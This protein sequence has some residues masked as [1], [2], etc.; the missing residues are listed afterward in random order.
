[1]GKGPNLGFPVDQSPQPAAPRKLYR[2]DE[3]GRIRVV[4]FSD[5]TVL[6][7]HMQ[8][9]KARWFGPRDPDGDGFRFMFQEGEGEPTTPADAKYPTPGGDYLR[10]VQREQDEHDRRSFGPDE[11]DGS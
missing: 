7:R 4:L 8:S 2:R 6:V 5:G 10:A 3:V 1:M 11:A 9:G